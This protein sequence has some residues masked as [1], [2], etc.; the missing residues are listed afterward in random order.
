MLFFIDSANIKEIEELYTYGIIDGVTTNPSLLA[1]E[2]GDFY[3]VAK[4]ICKLVDGPVSLEVSALDY[5]AMLKEGTKIL[6]IAENVVLK[7]P[8]TWDG[9][10]ACEHFAGKDALVNMTLCFSSTQALVAAKAGAAYIS[11]FI[12]RIDDIGGDGLVLIEEIQEIFAN[13]EWIDTQIL[14]ASI[15][16]TYHLQQAAMIGADIATVPANIIWQL[17]NHPLT[18][19]GLERFTSDWKKSG[20]KI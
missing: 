20:L 16:N 17:M 18:E 15:R 3:S 4:A 14:A 5:D 19:Q 2:G 13:Y 12:G 1:K 8:C 10:K 7:L 9:V 11:P 6:D